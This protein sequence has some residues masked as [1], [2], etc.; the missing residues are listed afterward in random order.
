MPADTPSDGISG[1]RRRDA[2]AREGIRQ[3]G[4]AVPA[5]EKG[6]VPAG[7]PGVLAG[8]FWGTRGKS[9][10]YSREILGYS[11][12]VIPE[13]SPFLGGDSPPSPGWILFR[14]YF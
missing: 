8:N 13:K 7:N 6:G 9:L 3:A 5:R 2:E 10:G 4:N 11:R 1:G 12:E 14:Y